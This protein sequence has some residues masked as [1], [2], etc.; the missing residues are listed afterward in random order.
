MNYSKLKSRYTKIYDKVRFG[1]TKNS[2]KKK[3]KARL[4]N[5][6]VFTKEHEKA[7]RDFFAPYEKVDMVYHQV[8][9][10]ST[11]NFSEK[12][13]PADLYFNVIDE[14]LNNKEAAKHMD[15]KCYYK[16]LFPGIKQPE[17]VVAKIGELYFDENDKVISYSEAKELVAKEKELFLKVASESCA[18]QGVSYINTEKGDMIKQFEEFNF[19]RDFIAQ[20]PV[21]QHKDMSAVNESSVNTLRII[22][23]LKEN[24]VKIYSA[25][26]RAGQK[27]AKCDNA[28][29]GGVAIGV[30]EDGKLKKYGYEISGKRYETHPTNGFVFEGHQLPSFDKAV[31]LVK[32]AHPM[33]PHFRLIS[34][35]IC[36]SEEGEP[37]LLE[38]NLC[39]GSLDVH[40]YNNGPLFG[41]DTKKILDEV[42][43]RNK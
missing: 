25:I 16:R 1:I 31:E 15:N 17:Y 23:L 33:M 22:S 39:R 10:E 11:G 27:G 26:V 3:Y 28:T 14:Y 35:D 36:I 30:T 41:E 37:I 20:R 5:T 40:Q 43:G 34:W 21:K 29:G 8:Y 7:V 38:A 18:G 24:E 2:L 6:G 4:K 13:L 9:F 12:Y 19:K 42:F 32:K